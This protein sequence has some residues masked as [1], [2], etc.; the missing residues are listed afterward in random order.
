MSTTPGTATAFPR[1]AFATLWRSYRGNAALQ[2]CTTAYDNRCAIRVSEALIV[3]GWPADA[4]ADPRY[5][6]KTSPH[7]C[8]RGA[9]DLA[10]FLRK[11]WG[12]R[13]HGWTARS[14]AT[15]APIDALIKKGVI[16][17]MNIPGFAGQ[18]HV[19]LWDGTKAVDQRTKTGQYWHAQTIWLWTL[20]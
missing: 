4:F 16:A 9:Q 10:A 8:A 18:G 14:S 12:N 3:A 20:R 19:D 2:L 13:D 11:V 5:G 6:G 15:D 7:G 1:P 17:F